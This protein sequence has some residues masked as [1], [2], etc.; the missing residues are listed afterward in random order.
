M[1]GTDDA[2]QSLM[3]QAVTV[4]FD[5]SA[6]TEAL[7]NISVTSE[8]DLMTAEMEAA[9]DDAM[10]MIDEILNAES[11]EEGPSFSIDG[12]GL[13][14]ST[15]P[16]ATQ[17]QTGATT[18]S[19]VSNSAENNLAEHIL[20][21]VEGYPPVV[22][23]TLK[24]PIVDSDNIL[25]AIK[26]NQVERQIIKETFAGGLEAIAAADPDGLYTALVEEND[27]EKAKIA[28]MIEALSELQTQANVAATGLDI[29]TMS[30]QIMS[31]SNDKLAELI[32]PSETSNLA[33]SATIADFLASTVEDEHFTDNAYTNTAKIIMIA[34]NLFNSAMTC[35][36]TVLSTFYRP[37]TNNQLHTAP[38]P[39]VYGTAADDLGS[40]PNCHTVFK[41]NFYSIVDRFARDSSST[42]SSTSSTRFA[43]NTQHNLMHDISSG[44]IT[45][46]MIWDHVNWLTCLL[47]NELIISAGIGRL[48]GSSLGERFLLS[49][50]STAPDTVPTQTFSKTVPFDQV[51]GSNVIESVSSR[52][53][54]S[55]GA[56][57]GG[58]LDYLALGEE[59]E[60]P[61]FVVM[62]FEVNSANLGEN[63]GNT[64]L[65]AGKKYFID[66][67]LQSIGQEQPD[68]SSLQNFS[69]QYGAFTT[70]MSSYMT[71]ILSLDQETSLAPEMIMARVLQDF[72]EVLV[73]AQKS[74]ADR[75][76]L[77][78][79]AAGLFINSQKE[80]STTQIPSGATISESYSYKDIARGCVVKCLRTLDAALEDSS[81]KLSGTKTNYDVSSNYT[82]EAPPTDSV[83]FDTVLRDAVKIYTG[84]LGLVDNGNTDIG[85]SENVADMDV[86]IDAHV[87]AGDLDAVPSV[88]N[89]TYPETFEIYD[90]T[91]ASSSNLINLISRTI[92]ELQAE[93]FNLATRDSAE[94]DYRS[95]TGETLLSGMDDDR[96]ITVMVDL[97][98]KI[99][100]LVLPGRS[101]SAS[102]AYYDDADEM[103]IN[104]GSI[105]TIWN[106][107]AVSASLTVI[108]KLI[109]SL[110]NGAVIDDTVYNTIGIAN[111]TQ[112]NRHNQ[113]CAGDFPAAHDFEATVQ[114][115]V[116]AASRISTHRY[117][118]KA[119]LKILET[120]ATSVQE[121][122]AALTEIFNILDG[123]IENTEDL[124]ESQLVLY[125]MFQSQS[126]KVAPVNTAISEQQNNLN[127][128]AYQT[129]LQKDEETPLF[130]RSDTFLSKSERLALTAF[131][132]EIY[133][134][135]AG[136]GGLQ[137]LS[138]GL[139]KGLIEAVS[140]PTYTI[141][142][143]RGESSATILTD[144]E[145]NQ[146]SSVSTSTTSM[147]RFVVSR[148]E[149]AYG[150]FGG[151]QID[152]MKNDVLGSYVDHTIDPELFILPNSIQFDPNVLDEEGVPPANNLQGIL[153]TTT[154]YRIRGGTIIEEI[155]GKTITDSALMVCATNCLKS[156]LIDLFMYETAKVRYSDGA[157]ITEK[158]ILTDAAY[159][160][161]SAVSENS[162]MCMAIASK[163]GFINLFDSTNKGL[164]T[165]QELTT[166]MTEPMPGVPPLHSSAD[167]Y[168][169]GYLSL[170]PMFTN[171]ETI[172]KTRQYERIYHILYD[173]PLVRNSFDPSLIESRQA[174]DAF[175]LRVALERVGSGRVS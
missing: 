53:Y 119:S 61:A 63:A 91:W 89:N 144:E 110:I 12:V 141:S 29:N 143:D 79:V 43:S 131:V 55:G 24:F 122:S 115:I 167:L 10:A 73:N 165:S 170:I 171:N 64:L 138:V 102:G 142:D 93:A 158:P 77:S 118:L 154:F 48:K 56:Y 45:P 111:I 107:S 54:E 83:F 57:E 41:K 49:E 157:C 69:S 71:E 58:L 72:K 59:V 17:A 51:F 1:A 36:P 132:S 5:T 88:L 123:N 32:Q 160:F 150:G 60:S 85:S 14:S 134:D 50:T 22:L 20:Q 21:T 133:N 130:F 166:L 4:D 2:A 44:E 87:L 126:G 124:T 120:I 3:A 137:I 98:T 146:L 135:Q 27:L 103:Q 139:P 128:V 127:C 162:Q 7:S 42:W 11:A 52:V 159:N 173:E 95:D 18:V 94:S 75:D 30:T 35:Y 84:G 175:S 47:S 90:E 136:M 114:D 66:M 129:I 23:S 155:P 172:I 152:E 26:L 125:E 145:F 16:I 140:R 100:S 147:L 116:E 113:P 81:F 80:H 97:Y 68:R 31:L 67:G 46:S 151:L 82:E 40:M 39:I 156:Y 38:G 148:Y 33:L 121:S 86:R 169:A 13:S 74:A 104:A 168:T 78:D 92:R 109:D 34:Q 101:Y 108:T 8:V 28:A 149:E 19:I 65:V 161:L 174:Y 9:F 37:G 62:P 106:Q 164:K 153:K 76:I 70:D 25:E 105:I 163:R 99:A 112:I 96:L 117:N 6:I 15:S